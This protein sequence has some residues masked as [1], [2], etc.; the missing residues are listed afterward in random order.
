MKKII[1]SQYK[2]SLAM[3]GNAVQSC[4]DSLWL[5]DTYKHPFWRVAYHTL[6]FVD[7]YLSTSV[8]SFRPWT[9]HVD[10]LESLG[11]I[12]HKNGKL[13]REGPPYLKNDVQT[14]CELVIDKIDSSVDG[15]DFDAD[16]GFPWLRFSKLELQ[17]YNIRHIQHHAGQLIERIRQNLDEPVGWVGTV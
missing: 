11:P 15:L 7:L 17:L 3:F 6:F 13:P 1:K 16:S 5:D 10:E 8:E 2:A 9:K 4:N 14:Y 12:I